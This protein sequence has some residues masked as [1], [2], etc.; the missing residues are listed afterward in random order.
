MSQWKNS[1]FVFRFSTRCTHTHNFFLILCNQLA[2]PIFIY[3][4]YGWILIIVNSLSYETEKKTKQ[5]ACPSFFKF[6]LFTSHNYMPTRFVNYF[7]IFLAFQSCDVN[8]CLFLSFESKKKKVKKYLHIS[9][10]FS[11]SYEP[12]NKS[13]VIILIWL[14][15]LLLACVWLYLI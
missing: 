6:W 7:L 1:L 4:Y 13:S 12:R 2:P 3:Y 9:I 11:L 15:R 10:Q 5:N 8:V 14:P